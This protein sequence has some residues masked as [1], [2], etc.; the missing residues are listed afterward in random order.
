M[1]VLSYV[2]TALLSFMSLSAFSEQ[3]EPADICEATAPGGCIPGDIS[4][5][6]QIDIY[7]RAPNSIYDCTFNL[8]KGEVGKVKTVKVNNRSTGLG[9][10]PGL[11]G[12]KIPLRTTVTTPNHTQGTLNFWIENRGVQARV[13]LSCIKR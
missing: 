6:R 5:E 2:G 13:H 10:G 4:R 11:E 9:I 3:L 12:G 1:K 8:L 7:F